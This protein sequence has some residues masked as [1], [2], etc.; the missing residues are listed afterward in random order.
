MLKE[1]TVNLPLSVLCRPL[2]PSLCCTGLCRA[3]LR[4]SAAGRRSNEST[5]HGTHGPSQVLILT[6][7]NYLLTW[8]NTTN[9][10]KFIFML[11]PLSYSCFCIYFIHFIYAKV[12][13]QIVLLFWREGSNLHRS[14]L[15]NS[16]AHYR[17]NLGW[18]IGR[19]IKE[20]TCFCSWN[21]LS[22]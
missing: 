21:K 18:W 1:L 11:Y 15:Q 6:H 9:F 17:T 5:S 16:A 2:S 13:C 19:K 8:F 20:E 4:W 22:L 3:S 10:H 14:S 7:C 12:K